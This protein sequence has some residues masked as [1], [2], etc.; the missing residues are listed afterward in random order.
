M[1]TAGLLLDM[2][3]RFTS[4]LCL[5]EGL[6][7]QKKN[8]HWD[9]RRKRYVQLQPGEQ[10]T[11]GGH[12]SS[13]KWAPESC[14]F[15]LTLD[16]ISQHQLS[17]KRLQENVTLQRHGSRHGQDP[18]GGAGLEACGLR[19]QGCCQPAHALNMQGLHS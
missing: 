14:D 12:L 6:S 4:G 3:L 1:P 5:Q 9:K 8:F 17:T 2:L 15:R 11:A 13:N 19:V 7:G 16:R 10:V 18:V